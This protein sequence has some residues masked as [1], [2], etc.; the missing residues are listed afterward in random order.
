MDQQK[1]ANPEVIKERGKA[2][3][4]NLKTMLS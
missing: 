4:A 3:L 2:N 1:T